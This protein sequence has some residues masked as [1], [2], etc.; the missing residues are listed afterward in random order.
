MI[1]PYREITST[2][3]RPIIQVIVRSKNY[4]AIYPVL[5]DSGADYCIFSFELA[6]KLEITLLKTKVEFKGVGKD[7]IIGRFGEVEIKINHVSY[8]TKVLFAEISKF[9]HGI[10]GQIGFF[11]HFDIKLS[12]SK[13]IIEIEPAKLTN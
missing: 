11:D 6:E 4:F 3:K 8:S 2:I 13:Q 5:I 9:G 1:Y 10:L 7:K 12:H